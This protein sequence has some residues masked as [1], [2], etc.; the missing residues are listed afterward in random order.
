MKQFSSVRSALIALSFF[1]VG[2]IV[3][4]CGDNGGGQGGQSG[5]DE[6]EVTFEAMPKTAGKVVAKIGKNINNTG[7]VKVKKGTEIEFTLTINDPT[8]YELDKW[9]GATGVPN[10]L[11]AKLEVKDNA[12]VVAKL[13]TKQTQEKKATLQAVVLKEGNNS[14]FTVDATKLN[15]AA[16]SAGADIELPYDKA[17][18]KAIKFEVTADPQD[19]TVT[20][21]PQ[22]AKTGH[23]FTNTA[24][25]VTITVVKKGNGTDTL[26]EFKK[27]TYKFNV[28]VEAQKKAVLTELNLVEVQNGN[29]EVYKFT[30]D[31]LKSALTESGVN[32]ELEYAKASGKAVKFMDTKNPT[33]ATVKYAL[34]PADN[35]VKPEESITFTKD[36]K[37]VKVTVE[38]E[39]H[40]STVYTFKIVV[41]KGN[42][43]EPKIKVVTD[44][45]YILN[46]E[47]M[48]EAKTKE[49]CTYVFKDDL[50]NSKA[51]FSAECESGVSP[52]YKFNNSDCNG[53]CTLDT[54]TKTL[55]ITL[56]KTDCDNVDYTLKLKK[57]A[58]PE[59]HQLKSIKIKNTT[60]TANDMILASTDGKKYTCELEV[61]DF[62]SGSTEKLVCTAGNTAPKNVKVKVQKTGDSAPIDIET[63]GQAP[64]E[65]EL[66]KI[67]DVED[68][69]F[70]ITLQIV[71][72]GDT[73]DKTT[74]YTIM[75][76]KKA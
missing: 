46:A 35:S 53:E 42:I 4:S 71:V 49:G 11:K 28:S 59:K 68:A 5:N 51:T 52:S 21:D 61:A 3:F 39:D 64:F 26:P 38:K 7:K 24:Q 29:T 50:E 62:A 73:A 23:T 67:T 18:G 6:V 19:S 45:N 15:E 22:D 25:T 30:E 74:T 47:Q 63:K 12:K 27:T 44:N 48:K 56:A 32:I 36:M 76:N 31:N 41:K 40:T 37:T 66:K 33:D 55:V 16:T 65:F 58:T 34:D 54:E 60:L 14:V 70:P 75:I 1:A 57:L 13:K 10:T 2:L 43:P 72:E 20:Y 8:Q 17:N 69:K 9:V